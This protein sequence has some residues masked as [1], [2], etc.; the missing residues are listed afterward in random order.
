MKT[1][2]LRFENTLVNESSLWSKTKSVLLHGRSFFTTLKNVY[3]TP[4]VKVAFL[5]KKKRLTRE[6]TFSPVVLLCSDS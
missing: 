6:G 4:V 2:L 5:E 1:K 3:Y